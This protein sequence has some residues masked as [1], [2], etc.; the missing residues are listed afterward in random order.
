MII[1]NL[2]PQTLKSEIKLQNTNSSLR[3]LLILLFLVVFVY[4]SIFVGA[5]LIMKNIFVNLNDETISIAKDTENYITQSETINKD[6][7]FISK[8]Q[9]DYVSWYMFFVQMSKTIKPE[10]KI[11]VLSIDKEKNLLSIQG[12][13]ETREELLAFEQSLRELNFMDDIKLSRDY[14]L[15][16]ENINFNIE[17]KFVKYE[18]K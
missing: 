7:N 14:L 3:F 9:K 15:E 10:I 6:I 13:A 2:I 8:I 5:Y 18:F 16:K 1:I 11:K 17:G 12:F 4:S